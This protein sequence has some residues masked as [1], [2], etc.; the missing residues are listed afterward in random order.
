MYYISVYIVIYITYKYSLY[1]Y[2]YL[3]T[4]FVYC[5]RKY[6]YGTVLDLF[7]S[8]VLLSFNFKTKL[9]IVNMII[10]GLFIV[11]RFVQVNKKPKSICPCMVRIVLAILLN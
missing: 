8:R 7:N 5:L 2:L 4:E 9:N 1:K 11:F 6:L 10:L 3:L